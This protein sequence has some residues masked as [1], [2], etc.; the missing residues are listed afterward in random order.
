MQKLLKKVLLLCL[1]VGA[2][3]CIRGDFRLEDC[4]YKIKV[5]LDFINTKPLDEDEE[6]VLNVIPSEDPESG[7]KH[8][9]TVDGTEV[10]LLPDEYEF[11]AHEPVDNIEVTGNTVTVEKNPDGS[12][13]EPPKFNGGS[14]IEKVIPKNDQTVDVPMHMQVRDLIVVIKF[15]GEGVPY[16]KTIDGNLDGIAVSRHINDGFEP[17]SMVK[18]PK[19]TEKGFV[20]YEFE[21][22]KETSNEFQGINTLL[23]IDGEGKQTLSLSLDTSLGIVKDYTLDVTSSLDDF[24]TVDIHK[25]WYIVLELELDVKLEMTLEKWKVGTESDLIAQ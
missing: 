7:K 6:L 3:S 1:V 10:E 16:I 17:V 20:L 22:N 12:I 5:N 8:T 13:K 2:T 18:R 11:I 19:A 21:E 15:K 23:G 9:T 14:I 4:S 25:P 24:H